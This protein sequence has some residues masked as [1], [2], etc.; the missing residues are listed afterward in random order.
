MDSTSLS[1]FEIVNINFY[2]TL[3]KFIINFIFVSLLVF[4]VYS[5]YSKN[6]VYIF[7]FFLSNLIVFFVSSLLNNLTLSVGF[8]FGIFAI[9]SILRFRTMSIPIK[10]MTYLFLS[11]SIAIINSLFNP[12]ISIIEILFANI[13]M[14]LFTY[15]IE[16]F[17]IKNE[18]S[19]IVI[20]DNI[21]L[22]KEQNHQ[23][24]IEDLRQRTGLNIIRLEIGAINF[25]RDSSEIKIYFST[26]KSSHFEID[27][28]LD[29]E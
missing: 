23:L 14:I 19:K 4:W 22:V 6:K 17:L 12:T 7:T 3:I 10:E 20:Y 15:V 18:S 2:L 25:I 1:N 21:E 29:D 24:L 16:R 26:K 11:I 5:N 27:K 13:S 8:S 9:F 28:D